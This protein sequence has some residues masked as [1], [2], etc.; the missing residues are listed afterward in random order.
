MEVKVNTDANIDGRDALA[1]HVEARVRA[2][3]ERFGDQITRVE[4]HLSDENAAKSGGDDKRCLMEARLAGRQ[5]AVASCDGANVEEA[6]SGAAKK[7]Q[8]LLESALGRSSDHKG[9]ASIRS[10]AGSEAE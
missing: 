8:R 5:P 1:H 3:L 9:A 7:M 6:L 10:E 2:A 4:V